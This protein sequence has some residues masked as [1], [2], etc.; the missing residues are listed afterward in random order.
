M[1][2]KR[3]D[4]TGQRFG[5][6]VAISPAGNIGRYTAW[7]CKCDCGNE[8]ILPS[9]ALRQNNRHDC[10]REIHRR[11]YTGQV[12]GNLTVLETVPNTNEWYCRCDCGELFI[13]SS[14]EFGKYR[15]CPH[16]HYPGNLHVA[17]F[18]ISLK[19]ARRSQD[20]DADFRAILQC[21]TPREEKFIVMRFRDKHTLNDC[22]EQF[23]V[24]HE[25]ARQIESRALKKLRRNCEYKRYLKSQF[26]TYYTPEWNL[27][28]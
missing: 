22:A 21:L 17:V 7:S 28:L 1:P 10:G 26:T 3:L 12:F 5:K 20:E 2:G 23:G 15:K 8:L 24:T 25:R 6:L 4:L 16:I 11:D 19:D 18:N 27:Q 13:T 9:Y 14:K